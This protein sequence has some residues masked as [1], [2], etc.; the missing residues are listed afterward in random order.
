M[1]ELRKDVL[2]TI[3]L[4]EAKEQAGGRWRSDVEIKF[5]GDAGG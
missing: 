5:I 3:G 4:M 2:S 1:A